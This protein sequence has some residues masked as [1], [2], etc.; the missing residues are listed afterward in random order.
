MICWNCETTNSNNDTFCF[1]CGKLLNN[2]TDKP[3]DPNYNKNIFITR[4]ERFASTEFIV[5]E[6]NQKKFRIQP[7]SSPK[8]KLI[9]V[10]GWGLLFV[11]TFV[12]MALGIYLVEFPIFLKNGIYSFCVLIEFSIGP[13][14]LLFFLPL[15]D[16]ERFYTEIDNCDQD[17]IIGKVKPRGIRHHKWIFTNDNDGKIIKKYTLTFTNKTN[18][19]IHVESKNYSNNFKFIRTDKGTAPEIDLYLN[20]KMVLRLILGP[21]YEKIERDHYKFYER[22]K[23]RILT[24]DGLNDNVVLFFATV[25]INKFKSRN[26]YFFSKSPF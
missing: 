2:L 17:K 21:E 14:F 22:T 10:V 23:F 15:I 18:G 13:Y 25:I 3:L 12:I 24:R 16:N 8:E 1:E 26:V 20:K 4:K 5:T 7:K 11:L 19:I 9:A 6:N